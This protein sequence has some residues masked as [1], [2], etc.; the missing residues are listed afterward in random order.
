VQT[1]G[2]IGS[3]EVQNVQQV[4]GCFCAIFSFTRQSVACRHSQA[5]VTKFVSAW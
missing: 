1:L 4:V 2:T 5:E 3:T